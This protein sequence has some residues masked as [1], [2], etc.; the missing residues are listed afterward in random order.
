[1]GG[2]GMTTNCMTCEYQIVQSIFSKLANLILPGSMLPDN[3]GDTQQFANKI[4]Q[5]V[6]TAIQCDTSVPVV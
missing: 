3:V 6:I 5:D 2:S 4:L 1:M